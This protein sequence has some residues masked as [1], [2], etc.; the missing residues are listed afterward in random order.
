MKKAILG[1][2]F[3][4]KHFFVNYVWLGIA[5]VLI[6]A[7]MDAQNPLEHR[8]FFI[9]AFI[10]FLTTIG[11][12]ILVAAIFSF[13]SSTY[14]F[15]EKIRVLLEDIIVKRNFLSNID[16]EGKKEALKSLIQPSIS[17]S[18]K[19]PNIGDYYGHFINKTL[20]I[21][22]KCVRSNYQI[23]ARAFIDKSAN[24][25]VVEA[26]Y[27]YRLY[28]SAADGFQDI[29]LGYQKD[30]NDGS[31]CEYVYISPPN[32]KRKEYKKDD[33][34]FEDINEGGDESSKATIPV[35]EVGKGYDRL[36]VELKVV[37]YGVD[38]W[39]LYPFK[40]LQPTDG[41]KFFLHCE[42]NLT[43]QHH[44]IFVVGANY[45][46]DISKNKS[47]MSVSCN[48][49]INEG[50]GLTVLISIPHVNSELKGSPISRPVSSE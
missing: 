14:D 1:T 15:V 33:I 3:W 2:A 21:G 19:Y 13:A 28:P 10:N 16:P 11:V 23:N 44:S 27:S 35:A 42:D 50:S 31:Y 32:G 38:H 24:K 17:E 46:L 25:V 48:Q 36:D 5:I 12:A 40:A 9:G 4:L 37:E 29:T 43:I 6:A 41:F 20:E 34:K 30:G 18:N 45:N 26:T 47:D 7:L 39:V 22:K 49:W 8:S